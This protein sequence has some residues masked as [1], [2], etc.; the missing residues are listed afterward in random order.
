MMK[1]LST[2]DSIIDSARELIWKDGYHAVSVDAICVKAD[3]TK[4]S[5]YHAFP[6]KEA[7]LVRIIELVWEFT[8]HNLGKIYSEDLPITDRFVKHFQWHVTLQEKIKANYG[9]VPGA[10]HMVLE[11]GVPAAALAVERRERAK[12]H[13][14]VACRVREVLAAH[15]KSIKHSDW[16][17]DVIMNLLSGLQLKARQ[18]NSLAPMENLPESVLALMGLAEPPKI[19]IDHIEKPSKVTRKTKIS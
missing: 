4:S 17:T 11:F 2:K 7:L 3:I 18:S 10:Y 19:D 9:F 12:F 13:H 16:L 15:N 5:F 6:S 8:W 14:F 1:T